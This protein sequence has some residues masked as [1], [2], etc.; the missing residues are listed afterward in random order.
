MQVDTSSAG[1]TKY[2]PTLP[3]HAQYC[4]FACSGSVDV[5]LG[6]IG[7]AVHCLVARLMSAI[8]RGWAWGNATPVSSKLGARA[9]HV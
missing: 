9:V 5:Q 1:A 6:I 3:M 2:L 7:V 4:F 8:G